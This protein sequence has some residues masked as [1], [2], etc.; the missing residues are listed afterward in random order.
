M[1]RRK[2]ELNPGRMDAEWPRQVAL[3]AEKVIGKNATIISRFCNGL[4]FCPRH[5]AYRLEDGREF[6]VY[7]FADYGDAVFFHIH[8]GG[9]MMTPETRPPRS[10]R[11]RS[12]ATCKNLY[13]LLLPIAPSTIRFSSRWTGR[14][15]RRVRSASEFGK[16][17]R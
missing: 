3:P 10:Q 12:K 6:F 1:V 8:F 5:H 7:C 11:C 9:E 13:V 17:G 2:G 15:W 14:I 16:I 4:S